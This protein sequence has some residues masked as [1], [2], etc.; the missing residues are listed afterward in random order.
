MLN[1]LG[2]LGFECACFPED[3]AQADCPLPALSGY[4]VGRC[5]CGRCT[6]YP[7]GD[8]RVYGK[9][10][11]CDDRRCEDL[12]GVVCGGSN[13]SLSF[14]SFALLLCLDYLKLLFKKK[15]IY[16]LR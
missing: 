9:T 16:C 3:P 13:C 1:T 12:D 6:C 7:P 14:T 5:E 8:S 4:L 15:G 2:Y 10:C 11:E